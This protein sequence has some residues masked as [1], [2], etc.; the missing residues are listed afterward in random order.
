MNFYSFFQGWVECVGCADRSC[1]DLLCHQKAT[2]VRLVAEKRLKEPVEKTFV[3]VV[4]KKQ[5][6]GK[7]FKQAAKDVTKALTDMEGESID[8]L[9]AALAGDG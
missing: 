9:E 2:G 5:A 7:M 8:A 4:P 3:N 6:L 1:F